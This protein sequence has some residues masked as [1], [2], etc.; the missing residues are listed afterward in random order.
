MK[1]FNTIKELFRAAKKTNKLLS[2][3]ELDKKYVVITN[4]LSYPQLVLKQ[5]YLVNDVES[6]AFYNF[7]KSAPEG[8]GKIYKFSEGLEKWGRMKGIHSVCP[9]AVSDKEKNEL[10]KDKESI[11]AYARKSNF[12][13]CVLDN[14]SMGCDSWEGPVTE[15]HYDEDGNRI[16]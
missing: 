7:D 14:L 4:T 11:L 3:E 13:D 1:F 10:K 8:K 2:V 15:I 6:S 5:S 16:N 12:C 9:F